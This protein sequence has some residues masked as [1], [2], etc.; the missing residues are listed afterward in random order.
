MMEHSVQKSEEEAGVGAK[1]VNYSVLGRA[2]GRT[3]VHMS[4][5]F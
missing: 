5:K 1:A 4:T 3:T 2:G